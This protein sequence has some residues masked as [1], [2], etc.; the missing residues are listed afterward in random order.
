MGLTLEHSRSAFLAVRAIG[1]QERPS[2]TDCFG[3]E[4]EGLDDISAGAE[5]AVDY[6]FDLVE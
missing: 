6:D 3:A 1:I 5:A 2:E 4:S